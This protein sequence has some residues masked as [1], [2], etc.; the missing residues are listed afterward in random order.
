M[1][2]TGGGR[3]PGNF[4]AT[5]LPT[6]GLKDAIDWRSRTDAAISRT[7][8]SGLTLGSDAVAAVAIA[9]PTGSAAITLAGDTIA[10]AGTCKTSV[11]A[12]ITLAGDT[13]ASV[14]T[15]AEAFSHVTLQGDI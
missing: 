1:P 13:V 10:S 9:E 11:S 8:S 5:I 14:S 3:S 2:T 12:A 15:S 6:L 4:Q 7:G